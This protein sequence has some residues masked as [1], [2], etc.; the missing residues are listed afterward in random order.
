MVFSITRS[1]L[2]VQRHGALYQYIFWCLG[3]GRFS[4]VM[5]CWSALK[6]KSVNNSPMQRSLRT[7]NRSKIQC[8]GRTQGLIGHMHRRDKKMPVVALRANLAK[9]ATRATRS[10]ARSDDLEIKTYKPN[11]K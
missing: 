9:E 10:H 7:L 6:R 4:G 3:R 11:Q 8:R 2:V 1:V 5:I